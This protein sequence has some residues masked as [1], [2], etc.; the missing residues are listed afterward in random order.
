MSSD[1]GLD[2]GKI[3]FQVGVNLVGSQV[4][5]VKEVDSTNELAK[6]Y[7]QNNAPEG[8]VFL[9]EFQSKGKG[10]SGRAWHS[11]SGAGIYLSVL[12]KPSIPAIQIP[13]LTLMAGVAAVKAINDFSPLPASLKWPNDI[14]LNGKKLGGILCERVSNEGRWGVVIGIG[15]NANQKRDQFPEELRDLATSLCLENGEA[16]DRTALV[17]SILKRLDQEYQVFLKEGTETLTKNWTQ[18]TDMLGKPVR[19]AHG[20]RL[21]C[22]TALRLDDQG[23]LVIRTQDGQERAFGSGEVT[24]HGG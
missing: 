7:F 14:L 5:A 13:P 8:M 15:I 4:L 1:K 3:K 20:D 12:L 2:A 10:R 19:L 24:L 11:P 22:G 6:R 18:L 21:I 9:A 16:V 17:I 23:R